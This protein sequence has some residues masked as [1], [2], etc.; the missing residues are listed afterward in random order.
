MTVEEFRASLR[1]DEP[2]QG[3]SAP[4]VALWWDARADSTGD[5]GNWDRAHKLVDSL[6]T[7]EGMAVHAYLHRK[8]GADWNADYWYQ[9]AGRNFHRPKLD[10]EWIEL[11]KGLLAQSG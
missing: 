11:V 10:D 2:P 5:S 9:R 1:A 3:L 6:E 4:L 8:E 7:R